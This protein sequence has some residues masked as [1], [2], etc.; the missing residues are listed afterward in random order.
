VLLISKPEFIE[1]PED[2]AD[3]ENGEDDLLIILPIVPILLEI[4]EALKER[5]FFRFL[6]CIVDA[7]DII[8]FWN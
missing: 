8:L 1:E 5:L 4:G 3:V 2:V 6:A 7:A